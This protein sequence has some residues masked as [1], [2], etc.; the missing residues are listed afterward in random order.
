M[1]SLSSDPTRYA[2]KFFARGDLSEA[3]RCFQD[4][5]TSDP[6]QP[7]ALHGMACL[8]RA[9]GRNAVAIALCG[10]ALKAAEGLPASRLAR[11]H[12]TMGLALMAEGHS[13]PARAALVVAQTL[14]PSDPRT[15][16]AL[17]EALLL[18]GR[19]DEAK[20]AFGEA[21]RLA[22]D[23]TGYLMRLGQIYLEDGQGEQA[24]IYFETV[25]R[26]CA[27]DGRAWANLGAVLFGL[28]QYGEAR[29]TLLR[30]C[31]LGPRTAETLNNFGLVLMALGD[32]PQ[33]RSILEE[34]L[35]LRPEDGRVANSLGTVLMEM[36]EDTVAGALFRA[37][38]ERESG[39]DREQARFNH[40][41]LLLGQGVFAQGWKEFESRHSLLGYRPQ[42]SAW[43]GSPG[44]E[45]IAVTAEQGLGDSVQF[46]RLLREA[47]KRRPL[48]LQFPAA[49]VVSFMPQ[50]GASRIL[51]RQGPVESEVSLLSLP[52]VL[53]VQGAPDQKPYLETGLDPVP[54]TIGVCWAGNPS[55]RFD[56]RRSLKPEWLDPL[57]DVSGL[58]FVSLQRGECPDWMEKVDLSTLRALT[59]AVSQCELVISVDTLVAHVAGATGRPLWL[60]NRRGGDWRWK[61][62]SWYQ[63]V[64]QFRPDGF[65]PE[66]WPLVIER[67]AEALRVWERQPTS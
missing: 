22:S 16:A 11:I 59:R 13:E 62:V 27:Q 53:G 47:A 7:D 41:T 54:K 52:F 48:R 61:D 5:L 8:A 2:F 3:A 19:R 55:Y 10:K 67:V 56:S 34:A 28:G 29:E 46:L 39:F 26:R 60:L 12:L 45:P 15:L 65:L 64:R 20:E 25:T 51:D 14:Q 33:A 17:G 32:L 1:R 66:D 21:V 40:A 23:D 6:T 37:V 36:D 58:R 9:N 63:N 57:R 30:A 18:L 38:M 44:E 4:I 35:S 43:D 24:V 50:L 31:E 49:D 42:V